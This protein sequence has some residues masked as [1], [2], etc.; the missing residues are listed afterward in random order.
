MELENPLSDLP[1]P[2]LDAADRMI[3]EYRTL[4]FSTST[5]PF[6]LF[7]DRLPE[8]TVSSVE[9]VDL[10]D[11]TIVTVAGIV[12]ARQRP[13]TA[14]GYTFV[15]LDDE[16]GT[17]NSIVKPHVYEKY[18]A[19]VR[20]EPFIVIRGRLQKD[21][22]SLNV[23]A[24]HVR[25]LRIEQAAREEIEMPAAHEWWTKRTEADEEVK[26]PYRFLTALRQTPPGA[27]SWG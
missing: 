20:M 22:D 11:D 12:T 1:F 25:P 9:L 5:H 18:R 4:R 16:Y 23:I 19:T 21:G 27:K 15:L 26:K 24:F 2:D 13:K 3:A 14:E 6:S 8:G 17:I 10:P 7:A